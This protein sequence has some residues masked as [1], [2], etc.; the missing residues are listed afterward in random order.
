MNTY[1]NKCNVLLEL[2]DQKATKP[3]VWYRC[4]TEGCGTRLLY[5]SEAGEIM[6]EDV[7]IFGGRTKEEE[8]DLIWMEKWLT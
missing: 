5:A 7:M 3:F 4:P 6:L 2:S 8:R 1:C